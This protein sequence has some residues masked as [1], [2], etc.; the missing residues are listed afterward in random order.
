MPVQRR[1]NELL[2]SAAPAR[3]GSAVQEVQEGAVRAPLAVDQQLQA[4]HG[5]SVQQHVTCVRIYQ[6]TD[7]RVLA[8][9]LIGMVLF[10][11]KVMGRCQKAALHHDKPT[12][13]ACIPD[14]PLHAHQAARRQH[15]LCCLGHHE[16]LHGQLQGGSRLWREPRRC[17]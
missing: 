8:R 14:Q 13:G 11:C 4:A 9:K 2:D 5:A 10:R 6:I 3:S 16:V 7:S 17:C 15:L 12:C 1:G